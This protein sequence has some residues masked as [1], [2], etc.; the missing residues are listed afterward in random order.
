[1]SNQDIIFINGLTIPITIGVYEWEKS[2]K[3]KII[4]DIEIITDISKASR[5]DDINS[6]IDY[7]L[8]SDEIINY[9]GSTSFDLVET[10]ATNVVDLIFKQSSASRIK[11]KV[12]KPKAIAAAVSV[13]VCID[14]TRIEN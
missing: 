11:L 4:L 10:L 9:L 8:I 13:G 2:I 6:T 12:T 5:E 3:Q 7:K 1:M 14:R